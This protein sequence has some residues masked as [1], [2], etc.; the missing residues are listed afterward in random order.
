MSLFVFFTQT[1][2]RREA[3]ATTPAKGTFGKAHP[4]ATTIHFLDRNNMGVADLT[5]SVPPE[6]LAQLSDAVMRAGKQMKALDLSDI[7]QKRMLNSF[8]S[9]ESSF[10]DFLAEHAV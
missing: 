3:V 1:N 2:E 6:A 4:S 10:N 7:G 8:Q 9:G 5:V